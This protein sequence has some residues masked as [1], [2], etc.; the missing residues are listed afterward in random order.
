MVIQKLNESFNCLILWEAFL[1]LKAMK[2]Y[3]INDILT[4]D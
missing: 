2:I 4:R 3:M 1:K